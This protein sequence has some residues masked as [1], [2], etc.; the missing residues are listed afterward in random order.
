MDT[1]G[2]ATLRPSLF[3]HYTYGGWQGTLEVKESLDGIFKLL[4]LGPSIFL[5]QSLEAAQFLILSEAP[6]R[7]TR[8]RHFPDWDD[9]QQ[10][11]IPTACG[12]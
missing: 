5:I 9:V 4:C 8:P 1:S 11:P 12:P 7:W 2:V 10:I 3:Q 6:T